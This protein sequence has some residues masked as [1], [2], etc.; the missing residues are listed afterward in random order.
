LADKAILKDV[1]RAGEIL[2][3]RDGRRLVVANRGDATAASVWFPGV[4]LL[5]KTG[6]RGQVV[7]ENE[8]TGETISAKSAPKGTR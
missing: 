3:L 5:V 2:L 7:I 4:R 1:L 6:K 8:D